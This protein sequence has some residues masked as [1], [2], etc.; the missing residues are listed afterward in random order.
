MMRLTSGI[1]SPNALSLC[2]DVDARGR[3]PNIKW[4]RV[5]LNMVDELA[6]IAVEEV[7]QAHRARGWHSKILLHPPSGP[8][9]S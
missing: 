7:K 6:S 4:S 9:P 3:P 8:W 5:V 1:L 2:G